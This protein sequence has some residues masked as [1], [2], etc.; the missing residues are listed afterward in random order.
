MGQINY[1]S[2]TQR[3]N[4]KMMLCKFIK[5]FIPT[6]IMNKN[7]IF[8]FLVI[9][10]LVEVVANIEHSFIVFVVG[11]LQSHFS[12]F[13]PSWLQPKT[14]WNI[15]ASSLSEEDTEKWKEWKKKLNSW[16]SRKREG[17]GKWDA[18]TAEKST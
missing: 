2:V 12:F 14:I 5:S 10:N 17:G 15:T 3:I 7:Y 1:H 16:G 13:F 11:E 18:A 4:E 6:K 8:L 9:L